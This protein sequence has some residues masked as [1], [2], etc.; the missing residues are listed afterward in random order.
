MLLPLMHALFS[1]IVSSIS[2]IFG[3]G[4]HV[5]VGHLDRGVSERAQDWFSGF[6][7]V[8]SHFC[9]VICSTSSW[10]FLPRFQG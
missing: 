7:Y 5:W 9:L 10:D 6:N 2:G 1:F 3:V 4:Y 8:S